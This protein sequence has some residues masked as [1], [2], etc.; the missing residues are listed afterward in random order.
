MET[1]R[2]EL[3][4]GYAIATIENDQVVVEEINVYDHQKKGTGRRLVKTIKDYALELTLPV[5]FI[6][7]S[8]K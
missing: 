2:F 1:K 5:V 8:K 6:R 4:N 7:K 3:K